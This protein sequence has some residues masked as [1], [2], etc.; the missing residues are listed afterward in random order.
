MSIVGNKEQN[1][2]KLCLEEMNKVYAK[3]I[4][5][6]LLGHKNQRRIPRSQHRL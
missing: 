5:I 2:H 4:V 6:I 1:A 3:Q